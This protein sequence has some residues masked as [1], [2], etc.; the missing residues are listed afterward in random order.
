[1]TAI[2]N[3]HTRTLANKPR[4]I[5]KIF[6][7]TTDRR[8]LGSVLDKARGQGLAD[9]TACYDLDDE[10]DRAVGVD[11][12]EIAE[13]IITMNSTARLRDLENDEEFEY[14]LV[15]PNE[16]DGRQ[17]CVSVLAPV[18]TAILG[19]RIGDIVQW[20]VPDGLVCLRVEEIVYQPE[21]EGI[22]DR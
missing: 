10:L 3:V 17:H 13:D 7:T 2:K 1:M 4:G 9:R 15:Y 19:C 14:T 16:I 11:P 12:W 18:G 21:R 6:V 20:P 5:R 22:Y 8:R